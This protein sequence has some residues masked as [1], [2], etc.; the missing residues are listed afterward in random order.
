MERLFTFIGVTTGQSAIMQ[1]F[2]AWAQYLG[3][4]GVSIVGCDLPIG[5]PPEQYRVVVQRMKENPN[6]MG[7]LVTTH[8]I[9]LYTACRDLFDWVDRYAELCGEVS[10][11][12]K[13]GTSFQGHA[14]DPIS[15]GKTLEKILGPGYWG[16]TGGHVLCLGA[17]GSGLAIALHLMTRQEKA[18]RPARIVAVDQNPN[19]LDSMRGVLSSLESDTE[20]QYVL[21]AD[22]ATNDS[23][24]AELPPGS[25]V[26]NATGMGKDAPGSPITDRARFPEGG[27][28]WELNYRGAL[29]FLHQANRQR[30][31]RNLAV[32]D[33]WDYFIHGWTSVME[34]V[35]DMEISRT[36]LAD[37]SEI[38]RAIRA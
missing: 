15:S 32:H 16:K 7:A 19:R 25:L 18:D 13:R 17:G 6:D 26:I 27:I 12:S 3:L 35:F 34:Q 5:A 37:L 10:C 29:D 22:A 9:D 36:Q 38:A 14:K 20:M 31:D 4:R 30:L 33:G 11:L 21:N 1:I 8:K 23:L 2:P 24:M 28:A